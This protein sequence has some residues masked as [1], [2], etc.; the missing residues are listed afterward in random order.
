MSTP[1][2]TTFV[3]ESE[4][5]LIDRLGRWRIYLRN[6]AIILTIAQ[7]SYVGASLVITVVAGRWIRP[8]DIGVW[9]ILTLTEV[10]S[11]FAALGIPN[12]FLRQFPIAKGA[13]ASANLNAR[14]SALYYSQHVQNLAGAGVIVFLGVTSPT[15]RG[16]AWLP[17]A[18]ILYYIYFVTG[19]W[20]LAAETYLRADGQFSKL[21]K[22]YL[23]FAVI[24]LASLSLLPL[25]GFY[26]F[27]IRWP[28]TMVLEWAVLQQ[29][30][31]LSVGTMIKLPDMR[32]LLSLAGRDGLPLVVVST[33]SAFALS[34]DRTWLALHASAANVGN[35]LIADSAKMFLSQLLG[36]IALVQYN[37]YA[38]AYGLAD[39]AAMRQSFYSAAKL[40]AGSYLLTVIL[41]P[42][43]ILI[44]VPLFIPRYA[45]GIPASLIVLGG[46]LGLTVASLGF[47]LTVTRR[48]FWWLGAEVAGLSVQFVLQRV[49]ATRM[50]AD[51][52]VATSWSIGEACIGIVMVIG[53]LRALRGR[54]KWQT[55]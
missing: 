32:T 48:Y 55:S 12:G 25:F 17:L 26:G 21:S 6:E 8:E 44:F 50:N 54:V 4:D 52:M 40:L 13:S 30:C 19:R 9:R 34:F 33:L 38:V 39:V 29:A 36:S 51:A 2:D 31:K 28:L 37:K 16:S 46:G 14:V 24:R 3:R 18:G 11:V 35:Y 49:L 10:Y 5:G 47:P 23:L 53:A 1:S 7:L 20:K 41:L 22:A 43:G 42:V 27:L 45:P 15:L